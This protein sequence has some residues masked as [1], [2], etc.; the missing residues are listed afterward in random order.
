M[1]QIAIFSDIHGNLLAL[2]AVLADIQSKNIYYK[3][4]LGDLVDFAP[5]GNEVIELIKN[6]K[7]P[8]LM[9]NHDERIAFD[10]PIIPL[11]KHD[12]EETAN[13]IVAIK[14]SKE[15]ITEDNKL[16]LGQLPYFMQLDFKVKHKHWKIQL[17]HGSMESNEVYLYESEPNSIFEDIFLK[18][19]AQIIVM[20]HTHLP[21]IKCIDQKWAINTGSVGRSKKKCKNATYLL[22]ELH[23]DQIHAEIIQVPFDITAVAHG[24]KASGIPNFYAEFLLSE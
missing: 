3:Y 7:I 22:L 18:T 1:I 14:N 19:H 10:L 23:E 16:F 24:I 13:R 8:C 17:I 21:F 12:A 11:E 4:C 5:W 9:G 15:T 20:G 6:E 2:N